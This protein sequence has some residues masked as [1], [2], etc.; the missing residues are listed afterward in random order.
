MDAGCFP[1]GSTCW[2]LC[3][4]DYNGSIVFS[5]CKKE[6]IVVEPCTAE[7]LG[8][9]WGIQTAIQRGILDAMFFSDAQVVVNCVLGNSRVATIAPIIDDCTMLLEELPC[10]SIH[11]VNRDRNC[12]AHSLVSIANKLGCND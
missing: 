8:L 7:A 12:N 4:M 2:G 5:A 3:I 9:R 10:S 6:S 1:D 11:F